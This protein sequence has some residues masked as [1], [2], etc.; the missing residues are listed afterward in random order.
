MDVNEDIV[1]VGVK[2]NEIDLFESQFPVKNGITYNSYVIKD[3]KIAVMDT[4]DVHFREEWLQNVD[5]ALDGATPDYLVVHHMEP[6][7]SAN[8][9][10]FMDRY[11]STT[12]V[13]SLKA[14]NMMKNFFDN[15]YAD[16]R[17]VVKEGDVLNLGRHELQFI[18]APMVHWP[19]VI[20]SY[21]K[22]SRAL[23]TADAFGT[24]GED[25][26][27]EHWS[28]E[29]RRYYIGI[30]GKFGMPVQTLLK[31]VSQLD[32]AMICPLHGPVLKEHLD[33][34]IGLYQTWSSYQPEK[35]GVVIAYASV[36]GHTQEA[37]RIL[38]EK[39]KEYGCPNVVTYDLCRCDMSQAVS[40]AF[41]Y[42]QLVVAS[43]T[44]NGDVFPAVHN[45]IH[46]LTSRDYKNR[47]VAFVENGSW[48]CTAAKVMQNMFAQSKNL[49][50]IENKV[51]VL[52][53]V[54]E[55][56]LAQIDALAKEL[57]Q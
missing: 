33:H 51:T 8:I 27:L 4:V 22:Y 26:S 30:V 19:E 37:V 39:L 5:E 55:N 23:F 54:N 34:Y 6:D 52:S 48:A 36:Y 3:E 50:L 35:D 57:C 53:A 43:P 32:V 28:D 46:H 16:R 12:I 24:F 20:M 25:M 47:R 18:N 56:S 45:F 13:S 2:D 11:P 17:V 9:A 42:S 44:Y 31:K 29:A 41:G 10:V 15:D 49:T 7:H 40:D 1:Y 14:F 38:S 21:D